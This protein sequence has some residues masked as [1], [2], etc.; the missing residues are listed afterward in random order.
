M[1]SIEMNFKNWREKKNLG[2]SVIISIF[3]KFS[4]FETLNKRKDAS[5]NPYTIT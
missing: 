1:N 2:Y 5:S 4:K 3:S